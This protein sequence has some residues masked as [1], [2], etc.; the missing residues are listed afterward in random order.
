MGAPSVYSRRCSSVCSHSSPETPNRFLLSFLF[1]YFFEAS[2]LSVSA[3]SR[4]SAGA[5]AHFSC[6]VRSG[7]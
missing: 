6:A 7:V 5:L 1:S 3:V 2:V 4:S